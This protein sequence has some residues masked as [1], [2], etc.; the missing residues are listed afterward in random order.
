MYTTKACFMKRIDS[1]DILKGT[2]IVLMSL[3][4]FRD[5]FHQEAFFFSPTDPEKTNSVTFFLRW[6]THYCAPVFAFLA[7]ISADIIGKKYDKRYLSKFLFSRGLWLVFVEIAI[8]NFGWRFDVEF[9]YIVFQVIWMLGICMILMSGLV[10]MKK[11]NIFIFSLVVIFGHNLLD[12]FDIS[13]NLIWAIL[14]QL[15][16]FSIGNSTTLVIAYPIIPWIGLMS[17]GYFFGYY[18]RRDFSTEKRIKLLKTLGLCFVGGF[19][20]VRFLN[21]YGNSRPW[22]QYE[23]LSQTI[24]SFMDP[25]K[26][27]PSLAYLLMTLGPIF[28][29]LALLE[30]SKKTLLS[31]VLMVFGRVPFFFYI[32]H[33][34][35]IHLFAML[36]AEFSGFGW[37]SMILK[38]PI[39]MLPSKLEGFGFSTFVMLLLWVCFVIFMYPICKKFGDYK[40][41]NKQKKWLSY[42]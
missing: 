2:I 1:L 13:G 25:Q 24:F 34:Y 16:L 4:H 28:I 36:A 5:Y 11:R 22:I 9:N 21:S 17:L 6:I 31:R 41:N 10:W 29:I 42:L 14:H 26:Y 15:E 8:L 23:T 32:L 39:W 35:F 18:F 3:D 7:G 20:L 19:F 27:P 37:E 40:I 12:L 30:T 38:D 33:I